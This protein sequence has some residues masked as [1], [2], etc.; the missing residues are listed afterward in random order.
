[1]KKIIKS[2]IKN[3]LALVDNLVGNS[4]IKNNTF[5]VILQTNY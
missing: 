2:I 5:Y 3:V 1:M 4:S